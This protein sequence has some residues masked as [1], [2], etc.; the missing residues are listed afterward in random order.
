MLACRQYLLQFRD[1][2]RRI[3]RSMAP[4]LP[5]G[6]FQIHMGEFKEHIK[7]ALFPHPFIQLMRLHTIGLCH[8]KNIVTGKN[9]LL[10]LIEKI[11][12]SRSVGNHAM[13]IDHTVIAVRLTVHKHLRLL[14]VDNGIDAETAHA[15]VQPEVGRIIERP[16]HSGIFPVEI[17]LCRGKGMQIILLPRF[18][19]SPGTAA[20]DG[21]PVGRRRAIRL[22]IPPDIPVCMFAVPR[23]CRIDKPRMLVGGMV[24]DQIHH[25]A[26]IPLLALSKQIFHVFH[27]AIGRVYSGKIRNVIAVVHHRRGVNRRQP[28]SPYAQCF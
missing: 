2:L 28:D 17:R 10:K 3:P 22:G 8:G 18:A 15:L 20:K 5:I 21:A 12:Y 26:D 6:K 24:I 27:C 11:Q 23:A 13:N 9:L 1:N 7:G 19:P 25:H 16:T 14:D 4:K